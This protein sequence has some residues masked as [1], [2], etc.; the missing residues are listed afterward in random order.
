MPAAIAP[1]LESIAGPIVSLL[2]S[3]TGSIGQSG[4]QNPLTQLLQGFEQAFTGSFQGQSAYP[5]SSYYPQS[6]VPYAQPVGGYGAFQPANAFLGCG[7]QFGDI[8]GRFASFGAGFRAGVTVGGGY[9]YPAYGGYGVQSNAL[10]GGDLTCAG[11]TINNMENQAEQ[12]AQS[13]NPADQLKAQQLMQKASQMFG[14]LS[15]LI[16][17][18]SQMEQSSIANI[19]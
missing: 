5:P 12:L 9:G 15:K 2:S 19:H 6:P 16:Q 11:N 18:L 17:Q 14:S 7:R 4:Q 3:V 13:S 10:P 1:L 8:A